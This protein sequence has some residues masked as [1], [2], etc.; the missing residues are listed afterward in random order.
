MVVH[1]H[2]QFGRLKGRWRCLAKKKYISNAYMPNVV[3]CCVQHNVC[4]LN[5]EHFLPEWNMEQPVLPEPDQVAYQCAQAHGHQAVC[6]AI[7]S[8]L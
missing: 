2:K 3:A 6:E 1:V 8:I 4:E 7:I 5:K